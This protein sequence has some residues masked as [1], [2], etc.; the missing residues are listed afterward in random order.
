MT[1]MMT[2]GRVV[3]TL[4]WPT[5]YSPDKTPAPT[6]RPLTIKQLPRDALRHFLAPR[7]K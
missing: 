6:S 5:L 2:A 1:V 3:A 4:A 7:P